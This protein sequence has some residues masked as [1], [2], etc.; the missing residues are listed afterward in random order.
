LQIF[1]LL[2]IASFVSSFFASFL[3]FGG[4][5][6]VPSSAMGQAGWAH[7]VLLPALRL[8]MLLLLLAGATTPPT[9]MG[10]DFFFHGR[11]CVW[12][13][14]HHTQQTPPPVACGTKAVDA[15][16]QHQPGIIKHHPNQI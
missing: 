7:S 6:C 16:E 15:Q 11:P 12:G 1:W 4:V 13:W 14:P 5:I 3:H 2:E 9:P 8:H 10:H